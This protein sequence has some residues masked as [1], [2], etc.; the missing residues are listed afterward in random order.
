MVVFLCISSYLTAV[1]GF[2]LRTF[3]IRLSAERHDT[4]PGVWQCFTVAAILLHPRS[5]RIFVGS[6]CYQ[7]PSS[8]FGE[9]EL[10]CPY[11]LWQ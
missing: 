4:K 10:I 6:I 5:G 2:C 1:G 8:N 7:H 9:L 3:L 11:S